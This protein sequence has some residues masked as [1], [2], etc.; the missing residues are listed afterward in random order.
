MDFVN[1]IKKLKDLTKS[2]KVKELCES[3]LSGGIKLDPESF[4]NSINEGDSNFSDNMKEHFDA[5]RNEQSEIA[6]RTAQT[7]MENWGGL[8]KNTSENS[9]SFLN[10]KEDSRLN[11]SLKDRL[12]D[13]SLIDGNTKSFIESQ[14]VNNLGILESIEI[15]KTKAVYSYP[16]TKI[17]CEQFNNL[18]QVKGVKE[19]LLAESFVNEFFKIGWDSDVKEILESL[20]EKIKKYSREIEVSKVLESLKNSGSYN[21]YSDL[22]D[23]LNSWLVTENKSTEVLLKDL[24]KWEF[25]PLVRNLSNSIKINESKNSGYLNIPRVS[26]GE[27]R[28]ESIFVPVFIGEGKTIF[29]LGGDLFS[30][31]SSNFNRL[32]ESE[33]NE[34][35]PKSYLDLLDICSK[36][37]VRID[38]N[39]VYISLGKNTVRI[40]EEGTNNSVYL[41][42]NKLS[43]TNNVD[44][45]KIIG[46]EVSSSLGARDNSLVNDI[47]T[48]YENYDS[49]VELDFAK[50]IVSNIYEG[51]SVNL[52][53]WENQIYLQKINE[54]MREKS[55]Y[56]VNGAQAVKTVKDYLRY[57]ISEGLTEFL[58][59][60]Y[61]KKSIMMN[62]RN[63]ILNNITIVESEIN[64][65]EKAFGE[66]PQLKDSKELNSAY[67]TLCEELSILREKW[68]YLNIEIEKVE[69]NLIEIDNDIYEDEKFKIGDFVKIKESGETGKVLSIDGS[70]GR[71]TVM[72]DNG[73]TSDYTVGEISDLEEALNKASEEGDSK[74][75]DE[76]GEEELK[77]GRKISKGELAKQRVHLGKFKAGHGF[78]SAPGKKDKI[79]FELK[80]STL[81][82]D[83]DHGYNTT[84]NEE[85]LLKKK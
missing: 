8:K 60:D 16:Q 63:E 18:I 65:I 39:G 21:F 13:L 22:A 38:E 32:S 78:A 35:V 54:T 41:G 20:S 10:E 26:Q 43:F 3:Y 79:D 6:K 48:I 1:Q 66:K 28:V 29:P 59:G 14:K 34:I 55:L 77:E 9:G 85:E 17:L 19:F 51:V 24:R 76:D 75:N 70:S 84:L 25:N 58:E 56:K 83:H 4:F 45:A 49:I 5:I 62:D 33:I 74:E 82:I 2:P 50:S 47:I 27:S 53:K 11:E 64:K 30:A 7:L 68:N 57:D 61:R 80:N 40:V 42:K 12:E 37:N 73:K 44:L 15:L 81:D 52:I 36:S 71:Y 69:D 67:N 46:V 72:L 23:I 31:G